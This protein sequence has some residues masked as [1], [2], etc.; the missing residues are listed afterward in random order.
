MIAWLYHHPP[1]YSDKDWAI[2][3]TPWFKYLRRSMFRQDP[4]IRRAM[5]EPTGYSLFIALFI[6][7]RLSHNVAIGLYVFV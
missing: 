5:L 3:D 4:D 1:V 2:P 6:N 7:T